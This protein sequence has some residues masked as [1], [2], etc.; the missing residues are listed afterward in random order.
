MLAG[1]FASEQGAPSTLQ[2]P[3]ARFSQVL[4]ALPSVGAESSSAMQP[5]DIKQRNRQ[6]Y[7]AVETLERLS[8]LKGSANDLWILRPGRG[9]HEVE[10]WSTTMRPDRRDDLVVDVPL[11]WFHHG[12]LNDLSGRALVTFLAIRGLVATS[13]YKP[14]GREW[15]LVPR[16]RR[17]RLAMD[18]RTWNDAIAELRSHRLVERARAAGTA[19][20]GVQGDEFAYRLTEHADVPLGRRRLGLPDVDTPLP[21]GARRLDLIN[22]DPPGMRPVLY[23][24]PFLSQRIFAPNS[25]LGG[26]KWYLSIRPWSESRAAFR[27]DPRAAPPGSDHWNDAVRSL[28]FLTDDFDVHLQGRLDGGSHV[29]RVSPKGSA[30]RVERQLEDLMP[31]FIPAEASPSRSDVHRL[32]RQ[33]VAQERGNRPPV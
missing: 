16:V 8:L 15:F 13:R 3:Q 33:L 18:R 30:D 27:I 2:V 12:W 26:L 29:G 21:V 31:Q 20:G 5:T 25:A 4:M 9:P 1:W 22:R 32:L 6:V 24:P 28:G 11:W 23:T 10:P 14:E 19:R 17:S 7:R